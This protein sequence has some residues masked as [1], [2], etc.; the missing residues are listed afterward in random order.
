MLCNSFCV[1]CEI[2]FSLC[3]CA[4]E[5]DIILP[6]IKACPTCLDVDDNSG[7]TARHLL[8]AVKAR[9]QR[10]EEQHD[11]VGII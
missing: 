3:Q 2:A 4:A 5:T 6:L 11:D 8:Q 9:I 1:L 7:K 10:Q